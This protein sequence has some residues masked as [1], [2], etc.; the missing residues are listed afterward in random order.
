MHLSYATK[1]TYTLYDL[2][3]LDFVQYAHFLAELHL[4]KCSLGSVNLETK[5]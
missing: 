5:T 1:I 3:K 4:K 2:I